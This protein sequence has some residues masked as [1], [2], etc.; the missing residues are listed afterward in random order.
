MLLLDEPFGALDAQ[1]RKELRRW[2]REIHDQTGHTTRVRH[3]RPGR[4]ARA[5]RPRRRD[6]RGHDR[7]GRHARRRLRPPGR[8]VRVRLHRR[9]ERAAGRRSRTTSCGSAAAPSAHRRPHDA[10]GEAP[11]SIS[12]RTMSSWSDGAGRACRRGRR[13]APRRRHAARRTRN[14]RR[15]AIA[16]KSTCPSIT[17]PA[18]SRIAFRPK[19][20]RGC[21]EGPVAVSAYPTQ[22][23]GGKRPA[24]SYPPLRWRGDRARTETLSGPA[25]SKSGFPPRGVGEPAWRVGGVATR[26][27]ASCRPASRTAV[28]SQIPTLTRP[29]GHRGSFHSRNVSPR[30]QSGKRHP[31]HRNS[32]VEDGD[33]AD[34]IVLEQ[35]LPQIAK[36]AADSAREIDEQQQ[37]LEAE[38]RP[39]AAAQSSTPGNRQH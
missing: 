30:H 29:Q 25:A 14:R 4:G 18:K 31:E 37:R 8:P 11:C 1:V 32:A 33:R 27:S 3:A 15:P 17:R 23:W 26:T 24:S 28:A 12:A 36:A 16:S 2:L 7:A 10:P 9:L 19:R 6:E 38:A 5:R 20:W 21:C 35:Q 22:R 34:R 39:G 13:L